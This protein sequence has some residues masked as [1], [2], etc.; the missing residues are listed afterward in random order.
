MD[1]SVWNTDEKGKPCSCAISL[2][3]IENRFY[4]FDSEA[5]LAASRAIEELAVR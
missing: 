5:V 4:L 2:G 3:M 1:A